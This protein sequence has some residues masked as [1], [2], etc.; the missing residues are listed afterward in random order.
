MHDYICRERIERAKRLLCG[1][2][3]I[4]LQQVATTCG[5]VTA[6]RLRLVFKRVT[7][8]TPLQY[9]AAERAQASPRPRARQKRPAQDHAG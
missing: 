5:L 2:E 1:S 7:G 3:R 6:E 4:K 8:Q 9:R